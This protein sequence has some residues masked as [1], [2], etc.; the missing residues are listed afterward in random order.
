MAFLIDPME[1]TFFRRLYEKGL[2]EGEEK[3]REKGRVE[4]MSKGRAEGEARF[5]LFALR[6]KFGP[7]PPSI[8]QRVQSATSNQLENW[9]AR[10][11]T[12]NTLDDVLNG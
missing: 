7:L 10:S 6:Q 4:G 8:E 3:G 9:L 12:A 2:T 1:D 5:F 11:L